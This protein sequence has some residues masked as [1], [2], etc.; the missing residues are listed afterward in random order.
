SGAMKSPALLG[1]S[2]CR[3]AGDPPFGFGEV[4]PANSGDLARG[5][6]I[7]NGGLLVL[8]YLHS[9]YADMAAEEGRQFRIGNEPKAAREIV[10]RLFPAFSPAAQSHAA[11]LCCHRPTAGKIA[12]P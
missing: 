6:D 4:E 3:I 7:G 2:R 5:I 8:I 11:G 10:A 1:S 12:D 9:V